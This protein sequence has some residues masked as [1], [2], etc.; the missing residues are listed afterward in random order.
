M[1]YIKISNDGEIEINAF[2]LIGASSKRNDETK[3]GF[4][5]SG[6]K[7]GMAF[8]LREGIKFRIYSGTNEVVISTKSVLHREQEFQVIQIDGEDTS[9]TTEM[10]PKWTHWGVVREI[11]CNAI[12]E[13]NDAITIVDDVEPEDDKT[14]FYIE[15]TADLMKIV[16]NWDQYFS[17]DRTDVVYTNVSGPI[18]SQGKIFW[19]RFD[20]Q[21]II[22]RKGIQCFMTETTSCFNYDLPWININESRE[23]DSMYDFKNRLVA[24]FAS[25]VD[26]NTLKI[27]LSK[28]DKG[29]KLARFEYDLP[30]S[31]MYNTMNI[32]AWIEACKGKTLV[33]S[34]IAGWYT[35]IISYDR[36]AYLLLPHELVNRIQKN[37]PDIKTLGEHMGD[38]SFMTIKQT[39]KHIFLLKEANA[40]FVEAEYAIDYPIHVVKFNDNYILGYANDEKIY[41]SEKIFDMGRRKLVEVIYEENEHIKT[42]FGDK[43]RE[44]QT[45]LIGQVISRME[46]KHSFFL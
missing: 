35:D 9:M 31:N 15:L 27:L 40:F 17:K 45:Y 12:D 3:I 41:V 22:Y 2:R 24:F 18:G 38:T 19:S 44:F 21:M 11:Y 26:A 30:W 14:I 46:E 32:P 16:D 29:M 20:D 33:S 7:Y 37:I 1:K 10:G 39:D 4:F 5:G 34:E 28:L 42:K 25:G 36:D 6:L 43:T 8:L 13:N 23:I